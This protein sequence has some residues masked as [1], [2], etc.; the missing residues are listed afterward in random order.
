MGFKDTLRKTVYKKSFIVSYLACISQ[1]R[2]APELMS[3]LDTTQEYI[4]RAFPNLFL[5][6][7]FR[8]L[9]VANIEKRIA[10]ERSSSVKQYSAI[11]EGYLDLISE[12]G[13]PRAK[14][15]IL[16]ALAD[17]D[18]WVNFWNTSDIFRVTLCDF[19]QIKQKWNLDERGSE[20][21]KLTIPFEITLRLILG[22]MSYHHM[23]DIISKQSKTETKSIPI[24]NTTLEAQT[25]TQLQNFLMASALLSARDPFMPKI[26]E[27]YISEQNKTPKSK[28][29]ILTLF[30]DYK[31]ESTRLYKLLA[32]EFLE[33][34]ITIRKILDKT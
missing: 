23:L 24:K 34:D 10:E 33:D 8:L 19:S 29:S 21:E 28:N 26:M 4:A 11:F 5:N 20:K 15:Y 30:Q 14:K 13:E 22:N 25:S 6:E 1:P 31:L 27:L 2:S 18:K 16:A 7:E 17:K 9:K 3:L 32:K 12:F